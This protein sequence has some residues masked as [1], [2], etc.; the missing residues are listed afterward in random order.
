MSISKCN[1]IKR[2]CLFKDTCYRYLQKEIKY[3]Y[4]TDFSL[5]NSINCSFYIETKD[6]GKSREIKNT[7]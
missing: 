7:K 4:I 6:G 1:P 2:D 5:E 3:Q